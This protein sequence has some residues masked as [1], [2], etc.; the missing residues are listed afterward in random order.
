MKKQE[1]RH[2]LQIL[3]KNKYLEKNSK[4]IYKVNIYK[5]KKEI[6]I[7]EWVFMVFKYLKEVIKNSKDLLIKEIIKM[8]Y[9]DNLKDLEI[10]RKLPISETLYYKYKRSIEDNIYHV[11]IYEGFVTKKEIEMEVK[12][13]GYDN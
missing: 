8:Y 4:G 3:R 12:I 9:F 7:P 13:D 11:L 1:I 6:E 2:Y 10:I 5:R